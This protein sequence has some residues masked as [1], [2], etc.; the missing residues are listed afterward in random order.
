M[1]KARIGIIGV[2]WWGTVGHLEP[3]S[4]DEKTE[5]VSVWSR[6]ED[7]ARERAARFNVPRYDT[8]TA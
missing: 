2:G 3:L 8:W 1:K 6:T 5:L 4:K 7:K